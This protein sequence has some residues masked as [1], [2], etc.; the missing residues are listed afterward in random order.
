MSARFARRSMA[1]G[2]AFSSLAFAGSASAAKLHGV[3]VQHNH[4]SHSLELALR[5]GRLVSVHTRR[6]VSAGRVVTISA[7]RLR[8]GTYVLHSLR[9]SH[10]VRHSVRIRGVVTFVNRQR[11]QFTVSGGGASLL[12][13]SPRHRLSR[14]TAASGGTM[15][16]VGEE[17][18]VETSIDSQGNLED[19]GVQDEG[20]A[21]GSIEL[22]GTILAVDTTSTPNTLTVSADGEDQSGQSVT[23]D[24]PSTFDI[25]MFSPG[26]EV[27]LTVSLQSDG[28]Y[29]L[30]G[31]SEDG[32]AGQANS[33]GDQQGCQGD[34]TDGS[35]TTSGSGSSGSTD[36]SGSSGSSDGSGT[37]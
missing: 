2:I 13:S 8:N 34:Q 32:S 18:S 15:P 5:G 24:V 31:S 14:A 27:N 10:R 29:L 35:C 19:Q 21:T 7:T 26:Q 28:T 36:G 23:V 6:N 22:E 1:V 33:S 17:V 11:G 9:T 25:T 12:I 30:L 37:S 16:T 20:S 4:R 3:V